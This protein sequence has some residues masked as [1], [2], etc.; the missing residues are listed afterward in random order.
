MRIDYIKSAVVCALMLSRCWG[1]AEHRKPNLV[2]VFADQWRAQAVG[3][4]V[5]ADGTI[6]YERK[7]PY[8]S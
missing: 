3:Y 7:E 1:G 8:D 5:D 2:F 6:P 4:T